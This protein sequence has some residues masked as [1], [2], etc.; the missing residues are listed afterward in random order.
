MDEQSA[1]IGEVRKVISV[2]H[3]SHRTEKTYIDWIYRYIFYHNKK[4]PSDLDYPEISQFLSFIANERQVSAATQNQALNAIMFL[5]REVLK[6]PTGDL[7]FK[8]A[9]DD[10]RLPVVLSKI[11]IK[12]ILSL[13]RGEP[14]LM[15]S[16]MYG[17]GIRLQECLE[18]R[19]KDVDYQQ[20]QITI[21]EGNGDNERKTF[22]PEAL[23]TG[24]K[25]Q[26]EKVKL[27]FE[28]NGV[29]PG[30]SGASLPESLMHKYPA[31]S[32]EE[33]WQ[34]IFPSVRPAVDPRYGTLKQHHRSESYIQKEFKKAIRQAGIVKNA[35][36][37]S[38]RHSFA[39]HLLENGI[40]IRLIQELLG[41]K[42]IRTTM[43]YKRIMNRDKF[44]IINPLDDL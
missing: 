14:L 19:I 11:E 25:R 20:N 15:T 10:K 1:F 8:Y 16:L 28:E 27:R 2:K 26:I 35:G 38:L 44:R 31:A 29:I 17:C 22:F 23:K 9:Q 24:L 37:H 21:R 12:E 42:D 32:M 40:D 13:L 34:Y 5:Y 36:C 4:K 43:V 41:H 30:F 39:T 7:K 6:K 33:G 18:L 3:Y